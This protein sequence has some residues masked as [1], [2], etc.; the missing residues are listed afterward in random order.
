MKIRYKDKNSTMK[1][2]ASRVHH[3]MEKLM[4]ALKKTTTNIT[5]DS[6]TLPE[7]K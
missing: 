7:E 1:S 4:H 6:S 5:N 2:K 3:R